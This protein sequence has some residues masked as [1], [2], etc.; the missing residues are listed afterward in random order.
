MTE[1]FA[2]SAKPVVAM[3]ATPANMALSSTAPAICFAL[4]PNR[5]MISLCELDIKVFNAN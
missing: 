4:L 1:N 5:R 2:P 3:L